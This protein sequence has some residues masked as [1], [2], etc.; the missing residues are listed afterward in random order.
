MQIN[1]YYLFINCFGLLIHFCFHANS[2]QM[3]NQFYTLTNN[4]SRLLMFGIYTRCQQ[5]DYLKQDKLECQ[6]D[7]H[8]K[9]Q[10]GPVAKNE[11]PRLPA[12]NFK[13][14]HIYMCTIVLLYF[15]VF[16]KG[17]SNSSNINSFYSFPAKLA[18]HV[19]NITM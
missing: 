15:D 17:Y 10:P 4:C 13:T 19:T 11:T 8:F 7:I 16:D 18:G 5:I 6:K 12:G 3:N 1:Y 9:T 2:L 14:T